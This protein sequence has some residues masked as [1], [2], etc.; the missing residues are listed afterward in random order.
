MQHIKSTILALA[1][2]L[3]SQ[4]IFGQDVHFSQYYNAPLTLN[5]AMTGLISED[6]RASVNYRS[7]WSS[8]SAPYETM[9]AS[10]DFALLKGR[11]YDD[12][13]G[14]GLLIMNDQA[15]DL[16]LRN[17]QAQLSLSYS[18][19][20][21]A[22]GNQYLTAGFQAGVVQSA[23]NATALLF[24]SQF[25]GVQ[26]NQN[27]N[28]GENIDRPNFFYTDLS[29]G[30]AWYY[31]PSQ[32][33]SFYFGM[34]L[35]HLNQPNISFYSNS[36]DRL[37]QRFTAHAGM[38]VPFTESLSLVPQIVLINQGPHTETTVGSLVKFSTHPDYG[39]DYKQTAIYMGAMFRIGD[40]F[41][42]MARFD[43]N[44]YSLTASYDA[45]TSSLS[46]ASRG[47]GGFEIA[48]VYRQFLFEGAGQR[49]PVGCPTF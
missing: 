4:T 13:V 33:V 43:F 16:N 23:F 5:P 6:V 20:L 8:V 29:A 19:A 47:D 22:D 35:A 12:Y 24:D 21:N 30:L 32:D 15:G 9:A 37:K 26:L 44:N 46:N 45:N 31:V 36:T 18:K 3:L 48:L 38:E 7:Q 34:A 11:L 49:G 28:S 14:L 2:I 40:A 27:I 25:D 41:I 42:P 10:V 17:T 1:L 39:V